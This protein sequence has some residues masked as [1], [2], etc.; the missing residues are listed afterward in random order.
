MD[1]WGPYKVMTRQGHKYFLTILDDHTR[2]VWIH[3]L[4]TKDK[5]FKAIVDF[6]NM[7]NNQYNKQVKRIRIDN[8]T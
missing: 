7:V 5:A 8:A 1:T 6:M 4:K 2:V 3:L